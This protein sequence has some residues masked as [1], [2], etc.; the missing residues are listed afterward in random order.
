[1]QILNVTAAWTLDALQTLS[2]NW[3]LPI[4]LRDEDSESLKGHRI[5]CMCKAGV[6]L[7]S[8]IVSLHE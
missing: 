8:I 5:P 4:P 3:E 7:I 2:I 6:E 1:M